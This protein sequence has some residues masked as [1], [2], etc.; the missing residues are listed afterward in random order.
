MDPSEMKNLVC[1]LVFI[2]NRNSTEGDTHEEISLLEQLFYL[3]SH[4]EKNAT[5]FLEE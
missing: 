2:V 1:R 4:L 3:F 5:C